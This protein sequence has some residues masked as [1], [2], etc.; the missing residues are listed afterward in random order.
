MGGDLSVEL[1]FTLTHPKPEPI[2][3]TDVKIEPKTPSLV[4]AT[5]TKTISTNNGVSSDQTVP[6]DHNLIEFDTRFVFYIFI[7]FY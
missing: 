3:E 5:E 6:V 1:P 7:G 4:K 2:C